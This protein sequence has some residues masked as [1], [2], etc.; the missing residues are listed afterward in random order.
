M[1]E[2][3]SSSMGDMDA[4]LTFFDGAMA[5]NLSP[6]LDISGKVSAAVPVGYWGQVLL[7]ESSPCRYAL[8]LTGEQ[9]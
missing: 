5:V 8:L 6:L 3:Q 4:V 2:S 7:L 9:D 1:S